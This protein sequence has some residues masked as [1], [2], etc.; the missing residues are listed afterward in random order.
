MPLSGVRLVPEDAH[1]I[2]GLAVNAAFKDARAL[3]EVLLASSK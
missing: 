3:E 1:E 2:G